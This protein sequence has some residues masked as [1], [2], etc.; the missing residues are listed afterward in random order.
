MYYDFIVIGSGIAGLDFAIDASK[1]GRVAVITKK[2][3]MESNSNYA[4]GGI[5]AVLDRHDSFANHIKDTLEA[6]CYLNDKKAVEVMVKEA[7]SAIERLVNLGAGFNRKN[8]TL[9]LTRE[10]GH[11]E[12]RIAHAKDATGKEIE[13]ALIYN[14]RQN[15]NIDCFESHI[16]VDLIIKKNVCY[17]VV[18][19]DDESKKL[20]IF[21]SKIIVL[22]TGGLGQVYSRN[23]NPKIATGDGFAMAF[24]AGVFMKHME[25][26]Q[27]HPTALQRK[28]KP[29]FLISETLRGEGGI[30]VNKKGVAFMK[31][32]HAKAELAP[33][34]I[35][36]RAVFEELKNGPVY[37]DIRHL[38][39][40]YLKAR[41]PY[42]YNELWWYGIKMEKDL[43]PVSPAAHYACGG[44]HTDLNGQTNIKDLFAIGEVAHTGVHGGN[45]LASNSLL[46]CVVFGS[47]SAKK[48]VKELKHINKKFE[49][50]KLP[51][52]NSRI[53]PEILFLKRQ[54][55]ALMWKNVGIVREPKKI[56][57]TLRQL[58]SIQKKADKIYRLGLNRNIIELRN[59]IQTA[60][61][62]TC[63][64]IER[65][66]SACAHF[67]K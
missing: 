27:F 2:E 55:Q 7:P 6:G 5:A 13:R 28:G 30:L 31:K 18:V 40:K 67:L 15:K 8:N 29:A 51:K 1:K 46:E 44:A 35:V 3:L 10:G 63:A 12:R 14:L 64:A 33:R 56:A 25:F 34:D 60:L 65:K 53:N 21:N 20:D 45:R 42:I 61:L 54:T 59:L 32:Y 38:G 57:Q 43:I 26:V 9:S 66:I 52:I 16:A 39:A 11:S 17:G 47:R 24:R 22:A 58:K 19:L 50:I 41:F 23:C 37:L 49:N 48:A 4:Q 36:S 62:I